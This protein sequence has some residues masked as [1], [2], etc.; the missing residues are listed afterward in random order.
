MGLI[1]NKK[2]DLVFMDIQMPVMDGY[3]A[4]TKIREWEQETSRETRI[5]IIAMTAHA[6]AGYR[7]QCIKIGMDDYITKP[8]NRN[9]FIDMAQ[10][11]LPSTSTDNIGS[12]KSMPLTS[13]QSESPVDI[14]NLLAEMQ[15]DTEIVVDLFDSF[16]NSLEQ[17]K[18]TTRRAFDTQNN[19]LLEKEVHAIKG[20]ALNVFAGDLARVAKELEEASKAEDTQISQNLF[21]RFEKS[22]DEA[23]AYMQNFVSTQT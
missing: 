16:S 23:Q 13:D 11:W 5:P 4:T 2:Y 22:I 18:V 21:L 9:D 12:S 8:L 7:K 20:A 3:E 17:Q 14:Y 10:K 6:L 15:G 1:K 19:P